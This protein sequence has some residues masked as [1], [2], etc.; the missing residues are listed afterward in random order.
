MALTIATDVFGRLPGTP[1][2][3]LSANDDR[4]R[5]TTLGCP[6]LSLTCANGAVIPVCR[7]DA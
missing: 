7:P 4:L 2:G 6:I 1:L 5:L 3:K